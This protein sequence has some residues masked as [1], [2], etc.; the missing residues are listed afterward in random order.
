MKKIYFNAKVYTGN[1]EYAQ[2]FI[3]EDGKFAKVGTNE[4]VLLE[5]QD[6]DLVDLK[7]KTVIAG[8][9]DSHGHLFMLAK[10]YG[11]LPLLGIESIDATIKEGKEFINMHPNANV[12]FGMGWDERS[13]TSGEIRKITKDDLDLISKDIP[14]ILSRACAH[15]MT[16]NSKAIEMSGITPDIK[17]DGGTFDY[18]KG[19]FYENAIKPFIDLIGDPSEDKLIKF[20]KK[21]MQ[22]CFSKGVT[23]FQVNDVSTSG[24]RDIVVSTYKKLYETEDNLMRIHHQ[25]SLPD[26]TDFDDFLKKEKKD[27]TF[28]TLMQDIGPMKLFKD[29]SLGARS[30][31]VKEEYLDSKGN[32]GI[33]VLNHEDCHKFLKYAYK[34]DMQVVTHVIGDKALNDMATAYA[35]YIGNNNPLRWGLIHTQLSDKED[36]ALIKNHNIATLVQP[37]FLRMDIQAVKNAV[38]ESLQS[39]S[40]AFGTMIKE[41]VHM[42]LSTD[43][44][45][46]SLDPFVNIYWAV[47]RKHPSDSEVFYENECL[48]IEQA[49]DAYTIESAYIEFKEDI[50]GQIKQGYLADFIVLDRDIFTIDINQ[51]PNTKVLMTFIGGKKV[52]EA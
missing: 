37:I 30:A 52:Y 46:D 7:E 33:E 50:K 44:P 21:S 15:M 14:I 1:G 49:V 48:T 4:E 24:A 11:Q 9:N 34:H 39:T 3:V 27:P 31:L 25:I 16:V 12:V 20:M 22:E 6:A 26:T 28:N 18:E 47:A 36:M 5:K 29:G 43:A 42:S 23:T 41:N 19:H 51:V 17:I 32:K 35:K 10:A 8:I 45:I 40:Y 38:S 2:G 13:F